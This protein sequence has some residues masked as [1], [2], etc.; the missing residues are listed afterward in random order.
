MPNK[1]QTKKH[2]RSSS[3][4]RL[5]RSSAKNNLTD[6]SS[7]S[8]STKRKASETSPTHLPEA[9]KTTQSKMSNPITLADLQALL[10]QQTTVIKNEIKTEI[11]SMSDELK[12]NFQTELSKLHERVEAVENS[13][14]SQ[15]SNLKADIDK[16]VNRL[17]SNDD[18]LIR[19]QK[20]N[21]LKINGI[22]HTANE[23]LYAIFCSIAKLVGFDTSDPM[24]KPELV[25][26]QKQSTH[27]NDFIP[28][29]L[30]IVKFVAN[31]IRNKFYGLYL[32]KASKEPILS[33]QIGLP[34]GNTV[35]IGEV[36][37][38][39]NQAIFTEAI[40]LKRDKKIV[41]VK[42]V[43][44]IVQIKS[45]QA[46]RFV[47]VKSKREFES[48]LASIMIPPPPTPAQYSTIAPTSSDSSTSNINSAAIVSQP[49]PIIPT[50]N[51]NGS[52]TQQ[53]QNQQ[54]QRTNSDKME[55]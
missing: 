39:H 42:T 17:N 8:E 41:K 31:H 36:L 35:R 7:P 51:A 19:I 15:M 9:K 13:V 53:H 38:P 25:R 2:Q 11:K 27:N 45:S 26:M 40:K 5:T 14:S 29:P 44:G 48:Y 43:D 4:S 54:Q 18:D 24:N 49:T 28:L 46:E 20:L 1:N 30:I 22:P 10:E 3:T 47:S 23:N 55:M 34:K 33:E 16:C 21:E 52:M 6:I 12:L 32:A 50:N 37:T